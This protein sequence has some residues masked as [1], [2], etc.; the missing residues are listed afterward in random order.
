[1]KKIAITSLCM[2]GLLA[3]HAQETIRL[4]PEGVPE[5]NGIVEPET[6]SEGNRIQNISVPDMT[7]Y[8]ANPDKNTGIAV[9]ICPGGGY[10]RHA[11]GHE[12]IDV[13]N[14]LTSEGIT[15]IVLKY[16]LPN[17]HAFIP[18]KDA[19]RALQLLRS[20]AEQYGFKSNRLGIA[21]FSAGGHL[22]STTGT[23]LP[24]AEKPDFMLLFYPV[25]SMNDAITHKGSKQNLLGKAFSHPDSIQY[26]SNETRV[27]TETPPTLLLLSDDDKA[28]V[29]ENSIRFY[30]ALKAKNVPASVL[31]FPK[32]GHG[33]GFQSK[34]QYHEVWKSY[35]LDWLKQTA[36]GN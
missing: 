22:A 24:K 2:L 28:V 35:L 3:M 11:A 20:N 26:Y 30:Q 18:L 7:L 14:W 15:A 17:G 9:L 10:I 25:I 13:A 33:W 32:G 31:I 23:H 29:P 12:G 36:I 1:M 6:V 16:R 21:G 4:W 8:R 27:T 5:T 34:F 19:R